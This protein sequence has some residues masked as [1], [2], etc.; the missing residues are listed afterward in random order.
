MQMEYYCKLRAYLFLLLYLKAA[1]S[2][3]ASLGEPV[4]G[5]GKAI[6]L[7]KDGIRHHVTDWNL[8]L[9]MGYGPQDIHSY[10]DSILEGYPLGDPISPSKKEVKSSSQASATSTVAYVPCP[11]RT[12]SSHNIFDEGKL[13]NLSS[14]VHVICMVKNFA[15]D[16]LVSHLKHNTSSSNYQLITPADAKLV[17][18]YSQDNESFPAS[19]RGCDVLIALTT[20]AT[21]NDTEKMERRCPGVCKPFPMIE[22]PVPY[23]IPPYDFNRSMSCSMTV[24]A[25]L[26]HFGGNT[27]QQN[28][29][30]SN[31]IA[32]N[33]D[34]I[35][36]SIARRRMEECLERGLWPIGSFSDSSGGSLHRHVKY[37]NSSYLLPHKS[38]FPRRKI[39]G[40]IIWIGSLSRYNML[41][42]QTE[43]LRMQDSPLPDSQKIFGWIAT[44]DSYACSKDFPGCK[45]PYAYHWMMPSTK[46]AYDGKT[47]WGCAQRRPL[48]ALSH[49]LLLFDPE[50]LL[51]VDDDTYVRVSLLKYGTVISNVLLHER[52]SAIAMGHLTGATQ[53]ITAL[54]YSIYLQY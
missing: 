12:S 2:Y 44:E 23:L 20:N 33:L 53:T 14:K 54:I 18:E 42:T 49:T 7:V 10:A 30:G 24:G 5:A 1:Y 48:R 38:R 6:Y 3:N 21:I 47:G 37:S 52:Q 45:S 28:A 11:C 9:S 25:A 26:T 36:H 40:L 4:R 27:H 46:M 39:Y 22:I 17:R 51:I 8:F 43:A 16:F 41:V 34:N 50:F 15:F 31:Q 32:R 13:F 35:L 19:A 29:H